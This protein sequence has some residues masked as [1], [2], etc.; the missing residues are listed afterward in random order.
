MVLLRAFLVLCALEYVTS[1]DV[2]PDMYNN[3]SEIIERSPGIS[4]GSS[5]YLEL[6]IAYGEQHKNKLK[7]KN[8]I[9]KYLRKFVDKINE[10]LLNQEKKNVLH[11]E[12]YLVDSS[13]FRDAYRALASRN[14]NVLD[15]ELLEPILG[16][17][18]KRFAKKMKGKHHRKNIDALLFLTTESIKNEE[19]QKMNFGI[20]PEVG[21]ICLT[22]H[23]I[24]AATDDAKTYSG[25]YSAARQLSRLMGSVY[26]GEDPPPKQFVPGSDGAR[27]CKYENGH[28]MGQPPRK[29]KNILKV[30][31]CTAHQY[32]NGLRH[33]GPGC[34]ESAKTK[35]M[36]LSNEAK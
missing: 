32:I 13:L 28:L 19:S 22:G 10:I 21:G 36:Q 35:E 18:V 34:Y 17:Y 4:V 8:Q 31:D 33:R 24:A 12:F 30:S 15:A 26:D 11:V 27:W 9:E 2:I 20:E 6:Y 23:N 29:E 25:V 3:N 1:L 7:D 16:V 5:A 14:K